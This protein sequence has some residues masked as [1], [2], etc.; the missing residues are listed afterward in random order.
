MLTVVFALH[1]VTVKYLCTR[2]VIVHI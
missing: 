2:L 1:L